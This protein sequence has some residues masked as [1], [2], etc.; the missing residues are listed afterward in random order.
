MTS[1]GRHDLVE[2][3]A[4]ALTIGETHFFRIR[5]QIEALRTVVLP[6]LIRR[7]ASERRLRLWSAGCSSGEEPYTLAILV[8][9][10]GA[11]LAGWDVDILATDLSP[12]ALDAAR[13]AEYGEWS[14]RDTPLVGARAVLRAGRQPL[15]VGRLYPGDGA[16]RPLQ[17]RGQPPGAARRP[18]D[19]DRSDS[20]PQRD[21]LFRGRGHA[22]AVR[23]LRG[24]AGRGRL[25]GPG[26][27]DPPPAL[28][29]L[30]EA[31]TLPHAILWRRR[32]AAGVSGAV[33]PPPLGRATA[34]RRPARPPRRGG[35]GAARRP[36]PT[37]GPGDPW[38]L[39]R[40]GDRAA[41]RMA[42]ERLV[43]AQPLVPE[44][45]LL[46]GLLRLDENAAPDAVNS[47]RRAAF[48]DPQDPF[49]HFSLGRAYRAVGDPRARRR[50]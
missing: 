8:R 16:L 43:E 39:A 5:P 40:G 38:K 27:S 35:A 18:R 33:A 25:A 47:L 31:V 13:R 42:A 29:E 24:G 41:A 2:A 49:T 34:A 44:A 32:A 1:E 28:P 21:D 36:P 45:H 4:S 12:P 20:V 30:F 50:R 17:S 14:F 6:D 10:Q 3:L 11:A 7:R 22:G 19:G 15:A 26:P 46:L 37:P 23:A 9:E 48:L